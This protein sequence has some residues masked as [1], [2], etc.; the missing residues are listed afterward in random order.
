M[1]VRMARTLTSCFQTLRST[2]SVQG[3]VSL[4]GG[5]STAR[6]SVLILHRG[7]IRLLALRDGVAQTGARS[8]AVLVS[9]MRVWLQGSRE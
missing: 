7:L 6:A 8:I 4:C 5:A 1:F 3:R 2:P 9:A